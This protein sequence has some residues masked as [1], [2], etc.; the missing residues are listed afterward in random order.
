M[1]LHKD[2]DPLF[3]ASSYMYRPCSLFQ[4]GL[5]IPMSF[6]RH[7]VSRLSKIRSPVAPTRDRSISHFLSR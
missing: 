2:D 1:V 7:C 3:E 6:D 4:P 5:E